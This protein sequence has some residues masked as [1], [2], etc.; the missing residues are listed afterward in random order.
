MKQTTLAYVK[1]GDA[2]LLLYRNRK[3]NDENAGKWIGVGGKLEFGESP[4]ECMCREVNEETG[5]TP[6]LYR[7]RGIVTFVSGEYCEYMHLF[8]VSAYTGDLT[9]CDEGELAFVPDEKMTDLPMWEGDR[10]FLDLLQ[11]DIPFFSLKLV[12]A[13]ERLTKT[14]LNGE[15]L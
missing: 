15:V 10:V 9:D 14:I 8:T 7:Y 5:L 4:E 6:T 2:T 3:E 11:K 1:R 13:G 12:Y